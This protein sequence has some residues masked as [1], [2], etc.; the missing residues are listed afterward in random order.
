VSE[1]NVCNSR[2]DNGT[3]EKRKGMKRM[4]EKEIRKQL[5]CLSN[6]GR[7]EKV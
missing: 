2:C 4:L 7:Y 1:I 6:R 3:K 5:I